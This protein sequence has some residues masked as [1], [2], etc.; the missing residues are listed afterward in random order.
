MKEEVGSSDQNGRGEEMQRRKPRKAVS[1]MGGEPGPFPDISRR[2]VT[3][4]GI[5]RGADSGPQGLI[6]R[7]K[8]RNAGGVAKARG[9][10]R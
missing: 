8:R 9:G 6:V 5:H 7:S 2:V 3:K 10:L 4:M 1:L